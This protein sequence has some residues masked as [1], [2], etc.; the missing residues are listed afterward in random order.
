MMPS[1]EISHP[2]SRMDGLEGGGG[3][4]LGGRG[5]L[6]GFS[7][8]G[9]ESDSP[10]GREE[11]HH[12]FGGANNYNNSNSLKFR[13]DLTRHPPLPVDPVNSTLYA[14]LLQY[15]TIQYSKI[16]MTMRNTINNCCTEFLLESRLFPA[17]IA[18]I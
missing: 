11:A 8:G 14:A 13:A 16:K 15:C 1:P 3:F 6:V 9:F 5:G 7:D 4:G 10:R 2:E 17:F 12:P 18:A